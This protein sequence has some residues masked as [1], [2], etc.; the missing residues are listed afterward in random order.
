MLQGTWPKG[1]EQSIGRPGTNRG[2][3]AFGFRHRGL[4]GGLVLVPAGLLTLFSSPLFPPQSHLNVPFD[5]AAWALFLAGTAIR[6]WA[7][8]YVGGRKRRCL[9]TDGPYSLCRNPLYL[10]SLLVALSSGLFLKSPFVL[11]A[12]GIVAMG[13][14]YATLPCEERELEYHHGSAYHDYCQRTSRFFP[15]WSSFHTPEVVEV[16]IRGLKLE[17]KRMLVWLWLPFFC[18]LLNHG[19]AANWWPL[20]LHLP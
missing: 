17:G 16:S 15:R 7:T 12:I 20:F 9:I 1:I 2:E 13:Y 10:G 11:A 18:E 3:K 8:C 5:L 14:I 4:I 6:T 19:R